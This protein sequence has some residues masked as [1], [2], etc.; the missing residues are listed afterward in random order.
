MTRDP[1]ASSVGT[2]GR[3]SNTD[4]AELIQRR[5][6]LGQRL[7]AIDVDARR[8][9]SPDSEER[10]VELENAEVLNEIARVAREELAVIDARIDHLRRTRESVNGGSR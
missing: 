9:L 6:V 5:A 8:G 10:A 1:Q 2:P 3:L 4:E 7:D